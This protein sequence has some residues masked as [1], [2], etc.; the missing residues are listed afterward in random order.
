MIK[1]RWKT[2]Y[3]LSLILSLEIL[4]IFFSSE[5]FIL[6]EEERNETAL[7]NS[8]CMK[9]SFLHVMLS[10]LYAGEHPICLNR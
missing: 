10:I 1:E 3:M 6:E 8:C 4:H 2:D 7:K 9:E 5:S